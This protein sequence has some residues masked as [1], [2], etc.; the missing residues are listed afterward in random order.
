MI[1]GLEKCQ[2]KV[3][4]L[5][6]SNEAKAVGQLTYIPTPCVMICT[7]NEDDI[8]IGCLRSLDEIGR[9]PD[10]DTDERL[11]ILDNTSERSKT[12]P[13]AY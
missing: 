12:M 13:P 6:F 1:A 3:Y 4:S 7:L 5:V 8:C 11:E 2:W 10:A 9:W